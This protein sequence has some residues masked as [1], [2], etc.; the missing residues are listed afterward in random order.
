[1]Q[2]QDKGA[3]VEEWCMRL[4]MMVRVGGCRWCWD[5]EEVGGDLG[6]TRTICTISCN[7][8]NYAT[9]VTCLLLC[10]RSLT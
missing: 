2:E 3:V 10:V 7:M 1:M 4:K 8:T 6:Y 9:I 5:E